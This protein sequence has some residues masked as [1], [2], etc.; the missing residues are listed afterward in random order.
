MSQAVA[1][2]GA[3]AGTSMPWGRIGILLASALLLLL[4]LN[5]LMDAGAR[6]SAPH[7]QRFD[8]A[9]GWYTA[10]A[11]TLPL[12]Q[13]PLLQQALDEMSAGSVCAGCPAEACEQKVIPFPLLAIDSQ[14]ATKAAAAS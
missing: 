5:Q 3:G 9:L 7:V 2:Q 4:V 6:V 8:A 11:L 10:G 14:A 1:G 12:C 13:V